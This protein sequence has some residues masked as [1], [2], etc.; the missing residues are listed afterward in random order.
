MGKQGKAMRWTLRIA[1]VL[2]VLLLA[3]AIWPVFGFAHIASAIEARDGAALGKLVDFKAL[4]KSLTKQIVA[5]YIE[6]TGREK[7]LGLMGKTLAV[8]IG[9]SYAEP[10]VAELLNEQT[11]MD[12]LTKGETSGSGGGAGVKIPAE[13]APFSK[14]ALQ[15]GWQTMVVLRIRAR[16][17]LHLS[18]A[19]QSAGQAVQGET[20][21]ERNAVEARRA[22]SAPAHA[23]RARAATHQAAHRKERIA[24]FRRLLFSLS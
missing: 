22:R 11:L 6:L 8:G 5:A 16:R 14:S 18:S 23:A 1:A 10:I 15:S 24:P 12:L 9:T 20:Q 13:F 7:Q 19:R 3:Y 2:A 17:L 21:P 4:R